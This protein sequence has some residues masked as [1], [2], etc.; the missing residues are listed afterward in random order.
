MDDIK[1]KTDAS[2]EEIQGSQTPTL[3]I[4]DQEV[5]ASWYVINNTYTTLLVLCICLI[6]ECICREDV[7]DYRRSSKPVIKCWLVSFY[8]VMQKD[9]SDFITAPGFKAGK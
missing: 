5:N 8:A 6:Y 9:I 7:T 4:N 3:K 2:Y 1:G